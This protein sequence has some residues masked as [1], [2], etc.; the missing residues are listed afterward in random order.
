MKRYIIIL[1]IV[2]LACVGMIWGAATVLRPGS[3]S[4]D[5]VRDI[6]T[7]PNK[8]TPLP[9]ETGTWTLMPPKIKVEYPYGDFIL[10]PTNWPDLII[11]YNGGSL[12]PVF[13][14]LER[15]FSNTTDIDTGLIYEPAPDGFEK[16]ISVITGDLTIKENSTVHIPVSFKIPAGLS[17]PERWEFDIRVAYGGSGFVNTACVQRWLIT[18]R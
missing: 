17:L 3:T 15:P 4:A 11:T 8:G 5:M 13:V 16:W 7:I 9:D 2:V 10:L 6:T 12:L 14:L 1:P 18:M